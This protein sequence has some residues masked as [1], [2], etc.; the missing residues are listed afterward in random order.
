[1]AAH[2]GDLVDRYLVVAVDLAGDEA[3]QRRRTIV[4]RKEGLAVEG[5]LGGIVE[6]LALAQHQPVV[7]R[8]ALE[9]EGAVADHAAGSREAEAPIARRSG[10]YTGNAVK[11]GQLLEEIGGRLGERD[12]ERGLVEGADAERLQR[13]AAG[14]DVVARSSRCRGCWRRGAP[15][16][17]S[18]SR[19]NE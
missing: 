5:D 1:M 3:A 4:H 8:V 18:I 13:Q 12:L 9:G 16:L 11:M 19:R 6:L 17:G 7:G 15:V 10:D 14:I 2:E